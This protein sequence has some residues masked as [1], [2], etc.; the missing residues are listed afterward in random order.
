MVME[1]AFIFTA[2][3]LCGVSVYYFCKANYCACTKAGE[4]DNPV[5]QYWLGAMC[6]AVMS[7]LLCCVALHVEKGTLLWLVLMVSC[8]S[9]AFISAKRNAK[10]RCT[11]AKQANALLTNEPN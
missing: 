8:F 2:L 7:L 1:I 3:L 6:S 10:K 5:N 11:K 9:G 4:C